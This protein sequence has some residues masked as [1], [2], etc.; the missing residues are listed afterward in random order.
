MEFQEETFGLTSSKPTF[1]PGI[2][3]EE[4][5]SREGANKVSQALK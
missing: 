1:S 2:N 5:E 3:Q 4:R